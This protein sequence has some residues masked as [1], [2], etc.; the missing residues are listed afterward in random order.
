MDKDQYNGI[1]RRNF[2]KWGGASLLSLP[3]ITNAKNAFGESINAWR[4]NYWRGSEG[5]EHF[6]NK[7]V[8]TKQINSGNIRARVDGWW[9]QFQLRDSDEDYWNWNF[10]ER[11]QSLV[12]QLDPEWQANKTFVAGG[13]AQPRRPRL[14]ARQLGGGLRGQ[15]AARG[16]APVSHAAER[17][18]RRPSLGRR[19]CG[20]SRPSRGR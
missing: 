18:R 8:N 3:F 5:S 11:L 17:P 13:P 20:G 14:L 15:P 2:L 10:D 9:R 4:K 19:A 6:V 7:L 12:I 1:Q 16:G